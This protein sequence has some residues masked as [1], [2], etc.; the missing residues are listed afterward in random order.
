MPHAAPAFVGQRTVLVR[1]SDFGWM[2]S[3]VK[4]QQNN[5]LFL[6]FTGKKTAFLVLLEKIRFL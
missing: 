5:L 2:F 3:W 1:K 4:I 6:I